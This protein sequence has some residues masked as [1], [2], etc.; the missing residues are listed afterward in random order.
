MNAEGFS[1]SPRGTLRAKPRAA[2]LRGMEP[3]APKNEWDELPA[4]GMSHPARR[5]GIFV[6]ALAAVCL[7]VFGCLGTSSLVFSRMSR[8]E[9]QSKFVLSEQEMSV[10]EPSYLLAFSVMAVALGVLPGLTY[11]VA[12]FGVRAGR[13]TATNVALYV[14]ITQAIVFG[15]LGLFSLLDAARS[16]DPQKLTMM[17]LTFG[18]FLALLGYTIRCLVR[19]LEHARQEQ[20]S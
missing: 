6:W 20:G 7:A 5:A 2:K 10:L 13:L 3:D 4:A 1:V 12:G 16:G 8:D 14:A 17:I 15:L 18:T 9:L 19:S 11:L